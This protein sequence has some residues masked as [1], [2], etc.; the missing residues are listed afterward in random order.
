MKKNLFWAASIACLCASCAND[1]V[2]EENRASDE[3]R[4]KAF[5]EGST[6]A[7]SVF[8]PSN[9]PTSF[10]LYAST[11]DGTIINGDTYTNNGS[12]VYENSIKRYWPE[13]G[14]VTFEALV[15][16]TKKDDGKV[17]FTVNATPASQ[18]DLIYAR[19]E[20]T[21]SD[22]PVALNFRHALSQIVF[23]ATNTQDKSL[24]VKIDEVILGNVKNAGVY[25]LPTA[26]TDDNISEETGHVGAEDKY[27]ES[28]RG[29]WT[30]TSGSAFYTLTGLNKTLNNTTNSVELS[31][32]NGAGALML[33]PGAT[34]AWDKTAMDLSNISSIS[35]TFFLL[36]VTISQTVKEGEAPAYIWGTETASKYIAIP[37]SF[38]WKEGKRYV[39]TFSFGNGTGGID[40]EDPT[41]PVFVPITFNV[42]VDEF[43]P[44]NGDIKVEETPATPAAPEEN[45]GEEGG[46]NAGE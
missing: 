40:P 34:T 24:T 8:C 16:G 13:T 32:A 22:T 25:E 33:I 4:F 29:Q 30:S 36:K 28:G 38:D 14:T 21:K 45:G 19:T 39:Y 31:A 44:V 3:I 17:D 10:T 26:N 42:T 15:N 41:K 1:G 11:T 43:V 37:V 2:I 7:G 18:T 5:A 23:K 20:A 9:L 12:G 6:R 35:G 46:E 27:K